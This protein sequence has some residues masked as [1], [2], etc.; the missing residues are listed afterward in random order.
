MTVKQGG[1][2]TR[3]SRSIDKN[4]CNA[5]SVNA[6]TLEWIGMAPI[7]DSGSSFGYD[8]SIPLM[9]DESETECKPFKKHHD[10][11]LKLVSSF[12]WI[13]FDKLSDVPQMITEILSDERASDYMEER[14][15]R[16]IAELTRKRIKKL[17]ALA[18]SGSR[19]QM[20][21]TE[22]DVEQNIAARYGKA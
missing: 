1:C 6:Q 11:Q 20:V 5:S 2:S 14:R 17:R 12:E 18:M 3:R 21:G 16:V 15:I 13:D 19:V 22:D 4:C 8:K 7:Y 10:E 9:R